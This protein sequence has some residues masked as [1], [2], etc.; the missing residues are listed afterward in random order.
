[1]EFIKGMDVSMIDE[2]E[3]RGALYYLKGEQLDLFKILHKSGVN[4]IRLRLWNRPYSEE[5]KAYG[6]GTNDIE[7]TIALAKRI[8]ENKMEFMLDFHYSDFWADPAKQIKPKDWKHLGGTE[9]QNAVYEYTKETLLKFEKQGCLPGVVQVGNEIT[10]GFLWPNGKV[11]NIEEMAALIKSGI[12][13]VREI[14]S[15]IKIL[16]HLDFGTDNKMY[17]QWF[18]NIEPFNLDFDII[19]MSFY[20]YWNGEIKQLIENMQDISITF[21]KDVLVAE[22][23]IG[24]TTD[25]LGCEGMLYSEE[26]ESKAGYPASEEGQRDFL[27]DLYK[28]I[29]GIPGNRGKGVLYWEPAWL[30]IPECKWANKIGCAYVNDTVEPGNSWA[31]QALF[32]SNGN[33]NLALIE[34]SQL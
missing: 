32:D 16:L 23:A 30:P 27:K 34:L 15:S 25:S 6:G 12:R 7:T 31:N 18:S 17:R 1:M 5:G 11:D 8:V 29:R 19:G 22:T 9:L 3:R 26:L 2:L 24:Y 14:K 13:A 28:A 33:A 20:P 21:N 4:L 10:N